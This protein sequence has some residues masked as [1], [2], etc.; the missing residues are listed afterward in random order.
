MRTNPARSCAALLQL[1]LPLFAPGM[2][3]ADGERLAATTN[4]PK[5]MT[6]GAGELGNYCRHTQMDVRDRELKVDEDRQTEEFLGLA[7]TIQSPF[8]QW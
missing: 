7:D 2:S 6:G 3:F 8:L 4:S 5:F 1:P